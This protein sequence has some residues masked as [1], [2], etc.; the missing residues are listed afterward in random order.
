LSASSNQTDITLD[1]VG[2]GDRYNLYYARE[3]VGMFEN[4]GVYEGA[5]VVQNVTPPVEVS[6]ESLKPVYF[7]R[8]TRIKDGTETKPSKEIAVTPRYTIANNGATIIDEVNRLEW[9]CCVA[10]QDW[11]NDTG[12]CDGE[13]LRVN[14]LGGAGALGLANDADARVPTIP[15]IYSLF[16]TGSEFYY[17]LENN[18]IEYTLEG[19]LEGPR[20]I[21]DLFVDPGTGVRYWAA[22]DCTQ[23]GMPSGDVAIFSWPGENSLGLAGKR[24]GSYNF[25][26]YLRVVKRLWTAFL[27]ANC[28]KANERDLLRC[29]RHS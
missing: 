14:Y 18:D 26:L 17:D 25:D 15:E 9:D 29:T 28:T 1:W 19:A 8:L 20:T 24:C 21:S 2:D 11:N 16:R 5:N 7:F 13:P 22:S 6:V 23:Y 3:S 4:Y 27:R 12:T 10:G